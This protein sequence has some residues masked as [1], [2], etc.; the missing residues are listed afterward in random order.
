[1]NFQL[2]TYDICHMYRN[3]FLIHHLKLNIC[4]VGLLSLHKLVPCRLW[5]TFLP[6]L[7]PPPPLMLAL[8][9][10]LAR[11]VRPCTPALNV[12]KI[13]VSCVM[14]GPFLSTITRSAL[15]P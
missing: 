15:Y 6:P 7:L 9:D 4:H 14:F 5:G 12:S 1:M 13:L 3:V 2:L 8:G 10:Q 11:A